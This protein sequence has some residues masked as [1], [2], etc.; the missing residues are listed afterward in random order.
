MIVCLFIQKSRRKRNIGLS[1]TP[2]SRASGAFEAQGKCSRSFATWSRL[3]LVESAIKDRAPPIC[4]ACEN[5]FLRDRRG[6]VS[7]QPPV[8]PNQV[9]GLHKCTYLRYRNHP[10]VCIEIRSPIQHRPKRYS[11]LVGLYMLIS[12]PT[13]TFGTDA[14]FEVLVLLSE[15]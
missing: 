8:R 7:Y 9:T 11:L 15:P 6:S 14:G 10:S 3:S 5:R 12:T 13:G 2:I 1:C 4:L